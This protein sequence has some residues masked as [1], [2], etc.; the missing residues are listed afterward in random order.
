MYQPASWCGGYKGT[1]NGGSYR[2]ALI[3]QSL[4]KNTA[5]SAALSYSN[6]CGQCGVGTTTGNAKACAAVVQATICSK[7]T[8]ACRCLRLV[9]HGKATV[10]EG[11]V[12]RVVILSVHRGVYHL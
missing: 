8:I 12:T 9:T 6:I 11:K 1:D 7:Y 10:L 2:D 3:V 5:N 4:V